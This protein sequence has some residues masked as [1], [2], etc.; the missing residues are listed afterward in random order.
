MYL[1]IAYL[2]AAFAGGIIVGLFAAL[3]VWRD[4]IMRNEPR[5][6]RVGKAMVIVF[7]F[8]IAVLI[9]LLILFPPCQ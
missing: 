7:A 8:C 9:T 5:A 1:F 6:K 4:E 2:L 3:S